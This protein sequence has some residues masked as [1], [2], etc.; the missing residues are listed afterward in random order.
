MKTIEKDFKDIEG[1]EMK[2][3]KAEILFCLS[4]YGNG[5]NPT[6]LSQSVEAMK[7]GLSMIR[8]LEDGEL[9][10]DNEKRVHTLTDKGRKAAKKMYGIEAD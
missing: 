3:I 2:L 7:Y 8:M 4:Y 6:Q 1:S 10:Y 5:L 9:D